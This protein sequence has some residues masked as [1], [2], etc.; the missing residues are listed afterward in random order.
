MTEGIGPA[1]A[2][3]LN[4]RPR[5]AKDSWNRPPFRIGERLFATV[6]PRHV[7]EVCLVE[8]GLVRLVFCSG[9]K[10]DYRPDELER[11]LS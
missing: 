5:F 1:R 4:P 11:E 6:D 7:G 10:A 8:T 3:G 2:A 9:M